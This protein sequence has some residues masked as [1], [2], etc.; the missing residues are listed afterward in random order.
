VSNEILGYAP[1]AE[2]GCE[3]QAAILQA[4]RKGAHLYTRCPDCGIDQRTG[5]QRQLNIWRAAA[6]KGEPPTPP[7]CIEGELVAGEKPKI[8]PTAVQSDWS[9]ELEEQQRQAQPQ[10]ESQPKAGPKWGPV[11]AGGGLLVGLGLLVKSI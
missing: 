3:Q 7:T 6:W 11:L 10:T 2:S 1:C 5:K 9:P 8:K 4:R